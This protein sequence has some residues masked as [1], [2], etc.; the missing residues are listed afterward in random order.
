MSG[1]SRARRPPKRMAEM[2]T[3]SGSS[4]LV[5]I[6]GHCLAATVKRELGWAAGPSLETHELPRQF[7]RPAG[8]VGSLPSHH[9]SPS[10]VTATLVKIVLRSMAAVML[11][12]VLTLVPGATPKNPASGL[13]ARSRPSGPMC[14]QAMSSPTVHTL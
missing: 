3:P 13:M 12:F 2:G 10:G 5:E 7:T 11:G 8:G 9:G 4:Q 14:I 1:A 6:D